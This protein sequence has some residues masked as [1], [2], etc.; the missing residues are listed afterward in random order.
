M[1][2]AITTIMMKHDDYLNSPLHDKVLAFEE[3]NHPA[4]PPKTEIG[5][6]GMTNFYLL[7]AIL[8][9][10]ML[11]ILGITGPMGLGY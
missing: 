5:R 7:L 10:F 6:R 1:V 3:S 11:W 2:L 8:A 9:A 4:S